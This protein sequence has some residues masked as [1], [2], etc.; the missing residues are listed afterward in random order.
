MIL[1]TQF[2]QLPLISVIYLELNRIQQGG[3]ESSVPYWSTECEYGAKFRTGGQSTGF[4]KS[5]ILK[6]P[7]SGTESGILPVR[8]G[9]RF[10]DPSTES[11]PDS[12]PVLQYG[13]R[14][15]STE[16]GP[17][18]DSRTPVR[19]LFR[20]QIPY[21]STESAPDSNPVLR[22]PVRDS[23]PAPYSSTEY[24]IFKSA[25][26]SSTTARRRRPVLEYGM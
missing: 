1:D 26:D 14:S 24:G 7:Y 17:E 12:N 6:M 8:Y 4:G 21:S 25:P 22:T 2:A 5:N 15:S 23:F 9:A 13:V 19:H 16:S 3:G 11:S 10:P 20:T 18:L